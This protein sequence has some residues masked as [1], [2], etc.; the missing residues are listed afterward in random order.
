MEPKEKWPAVTLSPGTLLAFEESDDEKS[1]QQPDSISKEPRT[2]TRH[3]LLNDP[4][5]TKFTTRD[6]FAFRARNEVSAGP[7]ST[8]TSIVNEL[9]QSPSPPPSGQYSIVFSDAA[10]KGSTTDIHHV[11]DHPAQ[12][13]N[14]RPRTAAGDA[15]DALP[16]PSS[17]T[18]PKPSSSR[19][20]QNSYSKSK[21]G[22]S[23]LPLMDPYPGAPH[24]LI[25]VKSKWSAKATG[26]LINLIRKHGIGKWSSIRN[27]SDVPEFKS[28]TSVQIKDKAMQ[29]KHD[30]IKIGA[31]LPRNF[32]KLKLRDRTI[33]ELAAQGKTEE[34]YKVETI[35]ECEMALKEW[36]TVHSES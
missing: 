9:Q 24:T 14:L 17:K 22:S 36:Y 5:Q 16:T 2:E 11:Q 12:Q 6:P 19:K 32:E 8:A 1:F 33:K 29:I 7:R 13:K 25:S 18:A 28:N 27:M 15:P 35:A 10:K 4:T 21:F 34:G 23:R 26:T 3:H 20:P 31:A 30:Y